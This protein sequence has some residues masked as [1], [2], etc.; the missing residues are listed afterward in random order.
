MSWHLRWVG[1]CQVIVPARPKT[2][3]ERPCRAQTP[4][5]EFTRSISQSFSPS[6]TPFCLTPIHFIVATPVP[7]RRPN[8]VVQPLGLNKKPEHR[9]SPTLESHARVTAPPGAAQQHHQP[10]FLN[11]AD[12]SRS[13]SWSNPIALPPPPLHSRLRTSLLLHYC[14]PL[15]FSYGFFCLGRAA[16]QQQSG[17]RGGGARGLPQ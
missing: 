15:L 17:R 7:P 14:Y 5:P 3:L 9:I 4:L 2:R 1:G 10:F 11:E 16:T 8:V 13:L 6:G 12:S